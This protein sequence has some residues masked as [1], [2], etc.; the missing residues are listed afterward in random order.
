VNGGGVRPGLTAFGEIGGDGPRG[1]CEANWLNNSGIA[2]CHDNGTAV[3]TSTLGWTQKINTGISVDVA[4]CA[5]YL[6]NLYQAEAGATTRF[7]P[8]VSSVGAGTVLSNAGGGTA[9]TNCG[10]IT[11]WGDRLVLAGDT[12]H[13]QVIYFS[14]IGD[15]TDWDYTDVDAGGA[16]ANNGSEGGEFG[17]NITALI[18]HNRDCLLVCGEDSIYAVRGNPKAGG[19]IYSLTKTV[20]PLTNNAWCK[21]GNDYTVMMTR[22]GLYSMRPGCGEPPVSMSRE[23]LPEDLTAIAMAGS[24]SVCLGYDSRF[25]GI[26][27]H[28]RLGVGGARTHWFYDLQSKGFWPMSY[29]VP[30]YVMD[31]APNLKSASSSTKSGMLA[32]EDGGAAFQYDTASTESINSYLFYG[33]IALGSPHTEGVLTE[34]AAVLSEDS[35]NTAWSVFVG[36]SPQEAFAST[37]AFTGA[38]WNRQGLNYVQN[39]LVR[40]TAMYIKVEDVSQSR[41]VVEEMMAIVRAAGQRRVG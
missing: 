1:W 40:G 31:L 33:P 4:S 6:L 8:L 32:I 37:V 30:N 16:W 27:I 34:I 17:D 29:G 11:S 23:V 19:Q 18:D 22:D 21:T 15:P 5:V 20:G 28:V 7:I 2:V 12:V 24:T 35:G 38:N 13:P 36:D 3:R 25:R 9:P 14:R 26:H 41:W 39:P 10:L